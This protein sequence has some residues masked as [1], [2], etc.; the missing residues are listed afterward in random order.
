M[1]ARQILGDLPGAVGGVV[2]DDDD[3]VGERGDGV[4]CGDGFR[5]DLCDVGGFVVG[6]E[7]QREAER[8]GGVGRVG[9]DGSDGHD[10]CRVHCEAT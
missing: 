2:V 1:L 5:D 8:V 3:F 6:G 9:G 10:F 7:D 4:E